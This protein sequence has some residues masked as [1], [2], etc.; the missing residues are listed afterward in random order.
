MVAPRLKLIFPIKGRSP[1]VWDNYKDSN[2]IISL[3]KI[4]IYIYTYIQISERGASIGAAKLDP[5]NYYTCMN[6]KTSSLARPIG[7]TMLHKLNEVI[8]MQKFHTY[9]L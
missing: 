2:Y 8:H 6:F 4:T 1:Y 3:E 5:V 7:G 9:G